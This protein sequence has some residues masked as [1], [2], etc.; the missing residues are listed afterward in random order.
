VNITLFILDHT[1]EEEGNPRGDIHTYRMALWAAHFGG[2]DQAFQNPSSEECLQK[3]RE[4]SGAYW[5]AYT[6]DE[7]QHS[8][9]HILPYPVQVDN[10]GN[11][12]A[13][14]APWN[15][16]PDTSASVLGCKSGYLP[17]KLTT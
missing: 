17:A 6:A 12:S 7:P 13:L 5:E 9:V 8:E 14:E 11:V 16:F 10:E 4:I 3:V 15:C 2:A 1:V